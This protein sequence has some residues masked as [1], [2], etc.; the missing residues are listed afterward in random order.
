MSEKED[1]YISVLVVEDEKPI[2]R[3]ICHKI[4]RINPKFKVVA[5]AFN[6]KQAMDKIKEESFDVLFL[7]IN[8]P[9]F[10]GLDI[11]KFIKEKK[12]N[13]YCVLLTGYQ[14]FE[15][16]QTA[17]R[18]NA[19]DYLLK[20]LD[21]TKLQEVL[22]KIEK[23]K[24]RERR[25]KILSYLTSLPHNIFERDNNTFST[26]YVSYILYNSLQG[27]LYLTET[28]DYMNSVRK[29]LL[30]N[31]KKEFRAN[32][33]ALI[34][35]IDIVEDILLFSS[36]VENL[37][38]KCKKIK[39]AMQ[40]DNKIFGMAL[41]TELKE[42]E[43]IRKTYRELRLE[44]TTYI[45]Y[46]T[47][48]LI[49][50]PYHWCQ[51]KEDKSK[52]WSLELIVDKVKGINA[53]A[54][55][56]QVKNLLKECLDSCDSHR[57]ISI[58]TVKTFFQYLCTKLPSNVHYLNIEDEII[59]I[60]ENSFNIDMAY[61]D[62]CSLIDDNFYFKVTALENKEQ[63]AQQ[64][65]DYIEANYQFTFSNQILSEKFGYVPYYLRRIFKEVYVVSPNEYIIKYRIEKSKEFLLK[66]MHA[67]DVAEIVGFKDPLYFSKVFKKIEGIAPTEYIKLHSCEE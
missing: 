5:T 27:K 23:Q 6:G 15:Y 10:S 52:N 40:S 51:P 25:N 16:A 12:I 67:K 37:R 33:F 55:S 54:T 59:E 45:S 50:T 26:A 49:T 44:L 20:P 2:S 18:N 47:C 31:L 4:E 32:E 11:L 1:N 30:L 61:K 35:G 43:D 64:I 36:D 19:F 8:I 57:I 7:D 46:K 24:E 17:L 53:N 56:S 14:T 41:N 28:V 21:T 42:I 65:H 38:E 29:S 58:K 62:L 22:S 13:S 9:F 63:L 60:M 48:I 34:E 3:N 66:N 39:K